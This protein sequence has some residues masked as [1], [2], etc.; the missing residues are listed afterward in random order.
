MP[1]SPTPNAP[2]TLE[3]LKELLKDD[4]KVKVAG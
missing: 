4:I 3:E 1:P 2:S